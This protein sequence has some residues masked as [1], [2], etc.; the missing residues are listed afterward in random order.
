MHLGS[1]ESTQ[2]VRVTLLTLLSS[3]PN[4]PRASITRYTHAKHEPILYS[5]S[6]HHQMMLLF[7]LAKSKKQFF[8]SMDLFR[9]GL[10]LASV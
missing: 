6:F 3:S 7:V 1:L 10:N 8:F 9:A 2:E 4:F 5:I